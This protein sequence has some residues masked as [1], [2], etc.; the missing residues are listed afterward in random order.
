VPNG[1]V[2]VYSNDCQKG[3]ACVGSAGST[4]CRAMCGYPTGEPGCDA[5]TCTRL[6]TLMNVGACL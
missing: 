2:C 1:D 6:T 4:T 3:S 5:G